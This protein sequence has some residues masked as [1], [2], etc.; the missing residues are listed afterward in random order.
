[1]REY[2]GSN[3]DWRG[4]KSQE[5]SDLAGR[6]NDQREH[7]FA[8][9]LNAAEAFE[10]RQLVEHLARIQPETRAAVIEAMAQSNKTEAVRLVTAT[11]GWDPNKMLKPRA[12]IVDKL[13]KA[14][15][16]KS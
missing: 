6:E 15:Q 8:K 10:K 2:R 13:I 1:M 5:R 7:G 11:F 12:Q 14:I 3:F 4:A 9:T 16:K